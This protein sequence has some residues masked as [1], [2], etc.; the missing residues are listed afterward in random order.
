MNAITT[1]FVFNYTGGLVNQAF[2]YRNP[3]II[4]DSAAYWSQNVCTTLVS[5]GTYNAAVGPGWV[6]DT[7]PIS[8][9]TSYYV[10]TTYDGTTCKISVNG[11]PFDAG[12]ACHVPQVLTNAVVVGCDYAVSGSGNPFIGELGDVV[13]YDQLLNSAQIAQ[14]IEWAHLRWGI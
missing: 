13:V 6:S 3:G 9:A 4:C 11:G 12:T 7:A 1:M 10:I 5:N 14:L 8:A 2:T